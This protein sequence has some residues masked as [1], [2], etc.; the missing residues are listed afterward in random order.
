MGTHQISL[1]IPDETVKRIAATNPDGMTRAAHINALLS[2]GLDALESAQNADTAAESDEAGTDGGTDETAAL[3]AAYQAHI[4][5][6]Q[7]MCDTL[8]EQVKA[9]NANAAAWSRAH[10]LAAG[11]PAALDGEVPTTLQ[12]DT[13]STEQ[14]GAF[15]RWMNRHGWVKRNGY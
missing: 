4:A 2:S 14:P 5:D 11:H 9:G 15:A 1:R 7:A 10:E 13:V 12:V 8:T 6:L 3:M